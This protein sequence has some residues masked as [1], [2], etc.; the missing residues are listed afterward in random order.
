M[1]DYIC[2]QN[3]AESVA[4]QPS[5]PIKV[6]ISKTVLIKPSNFKRRGKWKNKNESQQQPSQ[7]QIYREPLAIW[8]NVVCATTVGSLATTPETVVPPL[9]DTMSQR[10]MT[11][12]RRSLRW[13][14][15][16][17]TCRTTTSASTVLS[18][19]T[20]SQWRD[21]KSWWATGRERRSLAEGMCCFVSF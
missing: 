4:N 1:E 17:S 12:L 19:T 21:W 3:K 15:T 11:I 5:K 10:N 20:I 2:H 18:S 16:S 9:S 7:Q 6:N 8:R 14:H 13:C